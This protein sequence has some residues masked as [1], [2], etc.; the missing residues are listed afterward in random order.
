[1]HTYF[2]APASGVRNLLTRRL[3][4]RIAILCRQSNTL[5]SSRSESDATSDDR[6]GENTVGRIHVS[7]KVEIDNFPSPRE[8]AHSPES[9]SASTLQ[10]GED[11]ASA[12]RGA[13]AS[14]SPEKGEMRA[15]HRLPCS[16]HISANERTRPLTPVNQ[17]TPQRQPFELALGR[18]KRLAEQLHVAPLDLT[19]K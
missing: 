15:H 17:H 13:P 7:F 9:L 10:L 12:K 18:E 11:K 19:W 8:P 16:Q 14:S 6:G 2:A 4:Q 5:M 1:M 3:E